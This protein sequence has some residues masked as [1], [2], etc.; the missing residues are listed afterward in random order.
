MRY[1][2]NG[3]NT[4]TDVVS[5]LVAGLTGYLGTYMALN[6]EPK[7]AVIASGIL[8]VGGVVAKN[9][10][11]S[12]MAHEVLEAVGYGGFAGLGAWAAAALAKKNA[13]PVWQP[14]AVSVVASV[15]RYSPPPAPVPPASVVAQVAPAPPAQVV[16][17]GDN[18]KAGGGAGGVV[19]I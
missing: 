17:L 6:N 10:V 14:K 3:E 19:E 13:I 7:N 16:D 11:G 4:T 1:Q 12:P 15:P 9:Y 8:G 18:V 2:W 5:A